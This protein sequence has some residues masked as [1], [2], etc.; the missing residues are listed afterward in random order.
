MDFLL[1]IAKPHI[2][3]F[4]K[5]DKIHLEYFDSENGIADEKIKL[6]YKTKNKAFLNPND[7]FCRSIFS[8][9][10]GKKSYFPEVKNYELQRVNG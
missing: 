9:I 8:E 4:T 7:D 10:K 3:I 5:L 1:S 6:L 2:S